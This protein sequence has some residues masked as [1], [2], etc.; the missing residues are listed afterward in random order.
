MPLNIKFL[1]RDSIEKVINF[2]NNAQSDVIQK[3]NR[4]KEEFEWLFFKSS[5]KPALYAVATVSE[6]D[7]IIGTYA[8]IFIPMLTKNREKI[9]TI[10]GEDTLI[11]LDV[12]IRF[13]K[14][15]ILKELLQ[16]II[17]KSK[18]D[19][20]KIFWGFSN[21]RSAYRRCGFKI[22]TRIKGSFYVIS[23]LKF[24]NNR[25]EAL[26]N[27][28]MIKKLQLFVFSWYN[29]FGIKLRPVNT[30]KFRLKSITFDELNEKVLISF[31][32][33]NVYTTYLDKD[34][35]KWRIMENPSPLQ[36]GFIEFRDN[37]RMIMAY[38]IFSSNND[39]VYFVEQFLF[40]S[41]LVDNEKISIMKMAFN[42]CSKQGAIMVRAI[43]L[44]HNQ[45]N[46]KEMEL[47]SKT[48]LFFFNNPDESYLVF[49]DLSENGINPEDIYLS[50]LN[51]Q[52]I[53]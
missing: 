35:L 44:T 9:F 14:R 8:G 11:S 27:L 39:K 36:Y 41:H 49:K 25:L 17:E 1:Q 13:G 43:G 29:F 28:S 38:L 45:L 51:T 48:G 20:A 30:K 16:T 47:L 7:E 52:G 21:A 33:D 26:P 2:F 22:V 24:Y 50:R 19:K 37:N 32:P 34:F 18:D 42:Y 46:R 5:Y 15:D 4:S 23:P 53:R 6:S 3:N 10:K 31:L 12:M 40:E